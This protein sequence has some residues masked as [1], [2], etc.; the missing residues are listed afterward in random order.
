MEK[1]PYFKAASYEAKQG[2]V[3]KVVLLYS[4][5]LDTSCILEWI[6]EEYKANVVAVTLDLGQQVDDL[7]KIKLKALKHGA[8]SAHVLDLKDE[9]A[10]RYLSKAIKA[11]G[12]YQDDY[13]IS[14]ISRFIMAEKVL[15]IA[16]EEGADAIAHGCTGK[17]ND[18][19]RIEA[20]AL[21]LNPKIKIIAPVREW[22]MGREEELAY[23]RKHEI[24][25]VQ[26]PDFPYSSDDNM[27]GITWE[28][29]E[30][31][32]F[33]QIPKIEKFLTGTLVEHAPNDAE[34][35]KLQ[36][37]RGVPVVLNGKAMKL[38]EL[39]MACNKIGAKHGVGVFY[40]VEDRVVGLKVRGVYEHP[41]AHLIISAHKKLEMLVSSRLENQFKAIV[42]QKWGE[43]C[44]GAQWFDPLMDDLNSFC[45]KLNEK[46][47][48]TVTVKLYKG[49]A[50][51][52]A[53]DSPHALYDSRLATFMKDHTFNQNCSA[54][55]IELYGLQM[56]LAKQVQR[57]FAQ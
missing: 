8:V 52:V 31:E 1:V 35:V 16:Q 53:I 7:E 14:T 42:D 18:Q 4:G 19:I 10:E 3:K 28:S 20:S 37:E 9:F 26:R 40:M 21:A 51:V 49:N 57:G 39:I 41:G 56:K 48:G 38:S 27:W 29:G 34:L 24:E 43:I 5:G 25:V 13:Y 2:E 46:A 33:S 47:S 32:D 30:I 15:Q 55:F 54:G 11:N 45:D 12:T 22:S 17:G 36:F 23:A 44:Y 50:Q 6:Q